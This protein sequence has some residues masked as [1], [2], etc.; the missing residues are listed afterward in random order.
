MKIEGP[1]VFK[2]QTD[3][4]VGALIDDVSP[5][6]PVL[7]EIDMEERNIPVE[8]L[9]KIKVTMNDFWDA[10]REVSPSSM[11]EVLVESPNVNWD[12]VGG[13]T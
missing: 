12:D 9:Q 10:L 8:T 5:K 11:R 2:S 4:R 6:V 7:P 13:L 1:V 3:I